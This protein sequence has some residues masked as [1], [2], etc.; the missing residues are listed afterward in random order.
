MESYAKW[1]EIT[2]TDVVLCSYTSWVD[3]ALTER[4]SSHKITIKNYVTVV[5]TQDNDGVGNI[6]TI[7]TDGASYTKSGY[8]WNSCQGEV[9]AS[10]K[11]ITLTDAKLSWTCADYNKPIWFVGASYFSLGD[12]ARWPYYMYADKLT[13]DV[14][15]TGRGGMDGKA[16]LEEIRDALKYGKPEIMVWGIGMN[17]GAD[18]NGDINPKTYANKIEFLKICKENGI[19][20]VF[21]TIPNCGN[22]N[23]QNNDNTHKLDY[24]NNRLGDF[25]NYDYRVVN[26]EH[27]VNGYEAHAP[28][29][30]KMLH[31]DGT[32]PTNL[33]AR[34]FYM[35]LLCDFPELMLGADAKLYKSEADTI[36]AGS[37]LTIDGPEYLTSDMAIAFMADFSGDL[38]GTIEIG[39]GKDI[40]G[41]YWVEISK[42]SIKVYRNVGGVASEVHSVEN[43]ANMRDIV[44]V[45][46]MVKNNKASIALVSSGVNEYDSKET[47]LFKF[48]VDWGFAGDIFAVA[49]S[50]ELKDASLKWVVK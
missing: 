8:G 47:K 45:R 30:D 12:P 16:G 7:L 21:M 36:S 18:K 25:A 35:Q 49:S 37:V 44:L 42:S 1:V 39:N 20:A 32:H 38:S 31:S 41:G 3:P 11:N 43:P 17:D 4:A 29:Y 46:I 24:V 5:M 33:G 13:E 48:T 40:N 50:E 9:F 19:Q 27:A 22:E 34:N 23:N 2:A 26:I 28:W 15:I 14:F 10:S 6:M